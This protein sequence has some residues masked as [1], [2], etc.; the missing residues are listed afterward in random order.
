M[1]RF[2]VIA[3]WIAILLAAGFAFGHALSRIS[4]DAFGWTDAGWLVLG[5]AIA[6]LAT[7]RLGDQAG[8]CWCASKQAPFWRS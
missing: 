7:T 1:K 3:V 8:N 4:T 6:I 5:T 2:A